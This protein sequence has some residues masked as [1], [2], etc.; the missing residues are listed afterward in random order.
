MGEHD[1]HRERLRERFLAEGIRG[2]SAVQALEL[3]LTYAIPRK[4]TD[5]LAHVLL[6]RFGSLDQI[7]SASERELCEV[8]GVGKSTA[9]LLLLLPQLIKKSEIEKTVSVKQILR[10][11]DALEVLEPHY[12]FERDEIATALL[13]DAEHH[14]IRCVELSRG[15]VNAVDL[16]VRRVVE[17][18][19]CQRASHVILAHNHP[20]GNPHPSIDDDALTHELYD[21]LETVG[22]TLDDHLVLSANGNFSY[23]DSGSL[24]L[25]KYQNFGNP[26]QSMFGRRK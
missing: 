6:K 25:V 10:T 21:A 12:M 15:V 3:L 18:A 1:G 17:Y 16:S 7:F 20:G 8:P 11:R 22:I 23:R 13:L 2:F 26:R 24:S 19:L 4:D 9:A 5:D 14:L